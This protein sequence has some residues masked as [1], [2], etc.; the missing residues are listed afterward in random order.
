[1][2]VTCIRICI[3]HDSLIVTLMSGCADIK[4]P[5]TEWIEQK[6]LTLTTYCHLFYWALETDWNKIVQITLRGIKASA[7]LRQIYN[8]HSSLTTSINAQFLFA[9][10]CYNC[11]WRYWNQLVSLSYYSDEEENSSSNFNTYGHAEDVTCFSIY[12]ICLSGRLVMS[13][14]VHPC[15]FMDTVVVS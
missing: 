1:M 4:S 7:F 5:R 12:L 8:F 3:I 13:L 9:A 2:R 10:S 14:S 11:S 15:Y 6:I